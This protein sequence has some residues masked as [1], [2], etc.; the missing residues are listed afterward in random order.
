MKSIFNKENNDEIVARINKLSPDTKNLWGKMNVSQMLA[1]CIV[2][3]RTAIGEQKIKRA[4]AGIL[5][6]RFAKKVLIDDKPFK[7]GLPTAKEFIIRGDKNF[8]EEKSILINY[9]K[10]FPIEGE[11]IF[12]EESHPFFGKLSLTE[13][14]GLTFKHLDHHFR[15]FGV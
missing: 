7:T 15:Q 6:G 3:I 11:N 13:W 10:R 2:G 5:F 4:I 14:D 8:E 12:T 1:H 9:V